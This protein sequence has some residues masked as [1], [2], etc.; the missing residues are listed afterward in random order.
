MG[1]HQGLVRAADRITEQQRRDAE[2][3]FEK[4]KERKFEIG[5]VVITRKNR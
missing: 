5:N 2:Q 4:V 1:L 3:W